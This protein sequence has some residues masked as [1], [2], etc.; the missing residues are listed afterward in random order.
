MYMQQELARAVTRA[1][2]TRT[3][4]CG[5]ETGL[6]DRPNQICLSQEESQ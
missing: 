5:R 3:E 4:C 6:S 1:L 2:V